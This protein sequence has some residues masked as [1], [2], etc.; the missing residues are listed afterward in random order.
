MMKNRIE[1]RFQIENQ[2]VDTIYYSYVRVSRIFICLGE[3]LMD[4]ISCM[5]FSICHRNGGGGGGG[6]GC[7]QK[8]HAS[9]SLYNIRIP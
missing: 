3:N 6:D 7:I 5:K 2:F 8:Y 9:K 1:F 4:R